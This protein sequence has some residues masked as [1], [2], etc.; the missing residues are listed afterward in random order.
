MKK[1]L[2]TFVSIWD[3]GTEIRTACK[4]NPKTNDATDIELVDIN[5]L[6][7]LDEQYIEL[8]NGEIIKN[9]T[10]DGVEL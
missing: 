6:D 2:A 3:G 5:G 8:H 4:F 9:F 1:I 7:I 10:I